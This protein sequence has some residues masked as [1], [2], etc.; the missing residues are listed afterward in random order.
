MPYFV[1]LGANVV[2]APIGRPHSVENGDLLF[3][4]KMTSTMMANTLDD[5]E[6]SLKHIQAPSTTCAAKMNAC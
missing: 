1:S 2:F 6:I 3:E 5:I 4:R